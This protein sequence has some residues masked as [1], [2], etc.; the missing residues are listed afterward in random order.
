MKTLCVLVLNFEK[1][2][3]CGI[4][5]VYDHHFVPCVYNVGVLNLRPDKLGISM[6]PF[7]I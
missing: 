5:Y 3:N 6:T 1:D 4:N 7:K 2:S